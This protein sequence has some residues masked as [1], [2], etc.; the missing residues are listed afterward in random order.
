MKETI[1]DE[2]I[3]LY[4]HD[5][6]VSGCIAAVGGAYVTVIG[7]QEERKTEENRC[8]SFC[9]SEPERHK[10][11]LRLMKQS[12]KFH[13]PIILFVGAGGEFISRNLFEI[14]GIRVPVLS[15]ITGEGGTG[16]ELVQAVSNEVW[17]MKNSM[18]SVRRAILDFLK[19][20]K[21]RTAEELVEERYER[22][23]S[24]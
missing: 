11:I 24:M 2:F 15:V 18:D 19:R 21:E 8:R 9:R 4:G 20:Y 6:S 7:L 17:I 14:S 16:D 23:R 5:P 3:E 1:F 13:R 10:K 12:E 22:I